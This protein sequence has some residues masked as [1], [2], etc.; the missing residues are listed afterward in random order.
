MSFWHRLLRKPN[1]TD[2]EI[3]SLKEE[4]SEKRRKLDEAARA[5]VRA[6]ETAVRHKKENELAEMIGRIRANEGHD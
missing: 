2:L 1:G 3:A 4:F 5:F 6:T